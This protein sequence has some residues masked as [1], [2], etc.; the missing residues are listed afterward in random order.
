MMRENIRDDSLT[1]RRLGFDKLTRP[2]LQLV[3]FSRMLV[4]FNTDRF[5][6]TK[7]AVNAKEAITAFVTIAGLG[8][9]VY[10]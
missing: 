1:N 5:D 6:S 10:N 2:Q 7:D 4:L 9:L 3:I 8:N